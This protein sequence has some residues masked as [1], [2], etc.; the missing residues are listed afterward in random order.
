MI[1]ENFSEKII[2][3]IEEEKLKPKPRW[4]FVFKN[5]FLWTI[6]VLSLIFGAISFSLIIYL[7][8]S[9]G[10]I[11]LDRFG[12][13]LFEIF[14]AVV[15]IFWLLFLTF[16]IILFYLNLK[17]TRRAYKHSPFFILII[18]LISSIALGTSFYMF[19][20][21]KKLDSVF[22]KNI[23]PMVYGRFMNP[24]LDFWSEPEKGRL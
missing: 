9:R 6:G 13:S 12:A 2:S 11:F 4:E 19:G 7:F 22:G 24:Q 20:F 21:S 15:P 5:Y 23:N 16:F 3:K 10:S 18:G 8:N 14:L 1:E 17:K